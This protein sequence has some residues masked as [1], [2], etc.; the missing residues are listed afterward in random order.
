MS[1]RG[2]RRGGRGGGGRGRGQD[3]GRGQ[4]SQSFPC[5]GGG[6]DRGRARG[7]SG[8]PASYAMPPPQSVPAHRPS[9]SAEPLSQEFSQ[10]LTLDPVAATTAPPLSAS[11]TEAVR[12]RQRPGYGTLGEKCTVKTNHFL[13]DFATMELDVHHYDVTISPEV[14]SRKVNRDIMR[15]LSKTYKESH[16]GNRHLAYDGRNSFYTAGAL[17]FKSKVF[18]VKLLETDRGPS[19]STSTTV[20]KERQ[21][22]VAIKF[23]SKPDIHLLRE[24]LSGRHS[25]CPQE[26]IQVLDVVLRASQSEKYNVF[27]RSFFCPLFGRGKLGNLAEYS[28]GYYQGLRP[29]QMGLSLNIDVCAQ[30]FYEP[31]LVSEFVSKHFR[32][33]NLSS[34]LSDQDHIEVKK[35]LK[36]VRVQLNY[37]KY[38]QTSKIVGISREPTSQLMFTLDDTSTNVSV[39]QYFLDKYNIVLEYPSLPAIQSGSKA[40]HVYLPMELCRIVEGQRYTKRLNDQQV[41]QLLSKT[42]QRPDVRERGVKRVVEV[43]NFDADELVGKEFRIQVN[44]ELALIDARVLPPP[45]LKY[46]DSSIRPDFGSWNMID[47]KMV[48]GGRVKFWTCVNFSSK[49][50]NMSKVFCDELVEMC[51]NKGMD[52][53]NT[54][55]IEM[56]SACPAEIHESLSDIYRESAGKNKPLQ[57]LIVILP[58]QT[59]SYGK[60]KRICEIELGIVSQCCKPGGFFS[61]Q[62][63]ENLAL[64]INVKVG[65]RNTVLNDAIQK[66]IPLVTERPTIIFGAHVNHPLPGKDYSPSIAA[67][68]ASMDWPEITTY[69]G[70]VSAQTHREEIIQDLYKT[71][72]NPQKG[73]VHGGMIRELLIAF[74]K[75]TKL[76]PERIIFYRDGVSEGQ[77]SQV[78]LHEM[79]AIRKACASIQEGYL[80]PVTLVVVQKRHHTR[81][82]PTDRDKTVKSGNVL[83]GTVVDKKIC[84]PT[85]FDFYLNSHAAVEGTSKPTHYHV[86]FDE[87]GFSADNLQTLT[88]SLCYTYA[89][90]T[91]SVSIVPPAYYARLVAL[92][93]RYYA[94]DNGVDVRTLADIKDNVKEV[95]FYC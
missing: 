3:L 15:E 91:K 21:F 73:I 84:H 14:T 68:V 62:Y 67:V 66:R 69:R 29:T 26:T 74:N 81:L 9:S 4:P 77:F 94:K 54:P 79:D 61:K 80:P 57:L 71:I 48:N 10:K 18:V 27:G 53:C 13:V 2:G 65:G 45:V 59:G 90:C 32:P 8:P 17:P 55:S 35:A 28:M 78:L 85:E 83:P 56:R 30:L 43:N 11:S 72:E 12:F 87:N 64:K 42:C 16:L 50:K 36:G 1:D 6:G 24:F 88:N 89:R 7:S 76:K 31:I 22:K 44:K 82:F 58:D 40:R 95:M 33:Q 49:Y 70:V 75:S 37:L 41:R 39:A 5:G 52:F 23:A 38:P 51:N 63:F 93:A 20:R 60:I 47:K 34:P 19:S 86:L 92:R 46:C 25:E